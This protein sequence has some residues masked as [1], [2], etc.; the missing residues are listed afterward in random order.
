[1]LPTDCSFYSESDEEHASCAWPKKQTALVVSQCPF[2]G[3]ES[4]EEQVVTPKRLVVV[5]TP[6]AE[7]TSRLKDDLDPEAIVVHRS[8]LA[9]VH[10]HAYPEVHDLRF[11]CT[12]AQCIHKH[13]LLC[14]PPPV[15][16]WTQSTLH[17]H[18]FQTVVPPPR[19][20]S[21]DE[22]SSKKARPDD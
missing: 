8:E 2:C 17:D 21:D 14:D 18:W 12:R 10:R 16:R 1:M 4:D 15:K 13:K 6:R 20:L 19:S 3:R 7:W 22:P 5:S 9:A 11:R